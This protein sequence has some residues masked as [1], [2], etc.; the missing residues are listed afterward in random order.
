MHVEIRHEKILF[1]YCER[2]EQNGR[3][4]T[5]TIDPGYYCS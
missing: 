5:G 3:A 1:K 4:N 2:E